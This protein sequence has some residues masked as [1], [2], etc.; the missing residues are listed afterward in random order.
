MARGVYG[1]WCM[2]CKC[3]FC[4]CVYMYVCMSLCMHVCVF[5]CARVCVYVLNVYARCICVCMYIE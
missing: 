3:M 4:L 1:M 5:V 2:V